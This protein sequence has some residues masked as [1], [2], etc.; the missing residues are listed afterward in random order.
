[1]PPKKT[2]QSMGGMINFYEKIPKDLLDK[3]DN[4]NQQLHQIKIP[5]RICVVGP[6]GSGKTGWLLN[7]IYLFSQGYHK[8]KI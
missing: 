6:S 4:P 3:V 2:L 7:L 5:A 8:G 1:M